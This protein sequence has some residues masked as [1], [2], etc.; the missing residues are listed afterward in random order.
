MMHR[1]NDWFWDVK[2]ALTK[3]CQQQIKWCHDTLIS[4]PTNQKVLLSTS[5]DILTT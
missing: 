4:T 2:T 5:T 1:D 3:M